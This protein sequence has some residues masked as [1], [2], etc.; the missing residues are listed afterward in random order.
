ML[1]ALIEAFLDKATRSNIYVGLYGTDT[2]LY[3]CNEF[4]TKISEYDTITGKILS[5][6]QTISLFPASHFV[7]NE[8]KL[9]QAVKNI[10]DEFFILQL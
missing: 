3:D 9:Q 2:N 10:K 6:K 7:V 1:A 8:D 4:I 5:N